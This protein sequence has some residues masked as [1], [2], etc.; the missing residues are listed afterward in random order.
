VGEHLL[1][2][3]QELEF[4]ASS[5]ALTDLLHLIGEANQLVP[6]SKG[7]RQMKAILDISEVRYWMIIT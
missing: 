2:I 3:V 6:L 1:S 4:F 5:E 7:W